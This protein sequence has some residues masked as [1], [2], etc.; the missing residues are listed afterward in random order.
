M[1]I[2]ARSFRHPF[3]ATALALS[4][5]LCGGRATALF[6]EAPPSRAQT[7]PPQPPA[8]PLEQTTTPAGQA[9][10]VI[11]MHLH[12]RHADYIGPNPPPMC[13]PF[14]AMPR[15]DNALPSEEG[16]AFQEPPCEAPVFAAVTDEAVLR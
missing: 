12:A 14:A 5:L 10:P 1:A 9:P 15:W 8:A 16:F 4:A 11:D 6:G 2:R 7:P 3:R 13:A